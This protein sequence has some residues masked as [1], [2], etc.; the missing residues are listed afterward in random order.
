MKVIG[1]KKRTGSTLLT[2]LSITTLLA[3]LGFVVSEASMY[4]LHVA[5]SEAAQQTALDLARSAVSLSIAKLSENPDY[6]KNGTAAPMLEVPGTD[7][8]QRGVVVFEANQARDL[9]LPISSNNFSGT[10]A[11]T[12][13]EGN[14]VPKGSVRLVGVG[15]AGGVTRRVEAVVAIPPFPF[16]IASSGPVHASGGVEISGLKEMPS[17]GNFDAAPRTDGDLVSNDPAAKSIFLGAN[18]KISGSVQSAGTVEL[19]PSAPAGSI[20]VKGA[21]RNHSDHESIPNVKLSDY[22]PTNPSKPSAFTAIESPILSAG[23]NRISGRA[24]HQGSLEVQ[25]GLTLDGCQLFVNGDLKVTGGIHGKG[26]VVVTGKTELSGQSRL[27]GSDSVALLSGGDAVIT[28]SGSQGS[29]FKGLV[30]TNGRFLADK[31][32]LVGSLIAD[33]ER[34]RSPIALKD[35]RILRTEGGVTF[36]STLGSSSSSSGGAGS[37][38]QVDYAY[39]IYASVTCARNADSVRGN[40]PNVVIWPES[41]PFKFE[42]GRDGN[43]LVARGYFD[44]STPGRPFP[45]SSNPARAFDALTAEAIRQAKDRLAILE[46]GETVVSEITTIIQTLTNGTSGSSDPGGSVITIEPSSFLKLQERMR[47]VVWRENQ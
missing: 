43:Q 37:G 14:V 25:D 3:V 42:I 41:L 35:T 12:D 8:K 11:F 7:P 2:T 10:A 17:D 33:D 24:R 39:T 18:T 40:N 23:S 26:L 45:I 28:G 31:V 6:G 21:I 29:F 1:V 34:G 20:Q 44:G 19:D 15:Q 4:H 9:K 46:D 22:D 47:V 27:E 30:Y 5:S 36:S 13:A 38:G 16:A 32:T